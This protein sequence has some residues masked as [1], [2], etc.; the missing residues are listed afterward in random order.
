MR[1]GVPAGGTPYWDPGTD[2]GFPLR[3]PMPP[4]PRRMPRAMYAAVTLLVIAVA[5]SGAW[6]LSHRG[7]GSP[8]GPAQAGRHSAH[9]SAPAGVLQP[10][11]ASGFDPLSTPSQDPGDEN[12]NEARYAI[13]GSLATAWHTQYYF[14]SPR[15]GGLKAGTGLILDMGKPVRLSSVT[16]TFGPVPGADVR[17]GLGNSDARAPAA[18]R[19]FTTVARRGNLGGQQTFTVTSKAA[20]RFVLIWFTKLPPKTAGSA[21]RFEAEIFNVIVRGFR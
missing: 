4:G 15:F 2:T 19:T 21:H 5:V 16:V 6:V 11:G 9:A 12:S 18:L 8:T 14:G 1:G 7:N 13:D 10:V 3:D 20:G 17:I